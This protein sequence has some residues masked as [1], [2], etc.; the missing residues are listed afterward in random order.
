MQD[1]TIQLRYP[2]EMIDV[3]CYT[4]KVTEMDC[5][6]QGCP[7]QHYHITPHFW[8]ETKLNLGFELASKWDYDYI[9]IYPEEGDGPVPC[10]DWC[11]NGQIPEYRGNG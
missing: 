9:D 11:E 5:N 10:I 6:G 1:W 4:E 2:H 3:E 8:D 7:N